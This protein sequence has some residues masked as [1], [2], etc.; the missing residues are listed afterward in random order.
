MLQCDIVYQYK[1]VS[2]ST[3]AHEFLLLVFKAG[4]QLRVPRVKLEI[5]VAH[6]FQKVVQL[7]IAVLAPHERNDE[8]KV[9]Y[10]LL[11]N[12]IIKIRFSLPP[13]ADH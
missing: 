5:V 3:L 11:A 12:V 8:V 9:V 10:Q 6:T 13:V 2:D 7:R 4:H 1:D